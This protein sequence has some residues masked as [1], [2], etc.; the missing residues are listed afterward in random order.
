MQEPGLQLESVLVPEL[1]PEPVPVP[2]PVSTQEYVHGPLAQVQV[3][4]W[5]QEREQASA[6]ETMV[7]PLR[8]AL[9]CLGHRL[10]E[11]QRPSDD[12]TPRRHPDQRSRNRTWQ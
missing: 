2:E 5:A 6:L 9:S 10:P 12:Q 8:T 11:A 3:L 1:V 7:A 4:A